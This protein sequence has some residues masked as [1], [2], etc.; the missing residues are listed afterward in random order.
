MLS[1]VLLI[2]PNIIAF[3]SLAKDWKSHSSHWRRVGVLACIV[4]LLIVGVFNLRATNKQ[5]ESDKQELLV[6]NKQLNQNI[7]SLKFDLH[8][9]ETK[10]QTQ[11]ADA[12]T[13]LSHLTDKVVD[14]Q[15]K[16]QTADLQK[17]AAD[18]KAE[19]AKTQKA[20]EKPKAEIA[21]D[22]GENLIDENEPR[23]TIELERTGDHLT[24]PYRFANFSKAVAEN[25]F[26]EV[27]ICDAC[28]FAYDPEGAMKR[29]DMDSPRSRT[30]SLGN[31]NGKT[32]SPAGKLDVYVP[33]QYTSFTLI[34]KTRCA[35]CDV[36]DP[37][38]YHIN[39]KTTK[40]A[41]QAAHP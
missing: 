22:L 30:F 33:V 10:A 25:S 41:K 9:S 5:H 36:R 8:D 29:G 12:A 32:V 15:T 16:I 19:L 40:P 23:T 1:Y 39:I 3:F 24:I 14:L 2:V 27:V 35:N 21:L 6:Q 26:F 20:M 38:S 7:D 31:M 17:E 13:N 37:Q 11:A 4:V 18:L 34:V 28:S